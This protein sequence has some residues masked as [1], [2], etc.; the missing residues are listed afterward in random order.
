MALL[1]KLAP[2]DV[3][4]PE[5]MEVVEMVEMVEVVAPPE[6]VEV[7]EVVAPLEVVWVV[8]SLPR[9]IPRL[10]GNHLAMALVANALRDPRLHPSCT[11]H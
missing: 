2:L 3:V 5:V 8:A 7:V 9:K 10:R 11:C 4:P 1:K 6:V